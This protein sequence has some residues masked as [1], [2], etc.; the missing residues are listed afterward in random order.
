MA[1]FTKICKQCGLPFETNSPQ[2]LFCDRQHYTACPVCGQLVIKWDRDFTRPPVCCSTE[3]TVKLKEAHLPIKKCEICGEPFKAKSGVATI[4]EKE[5]H[6]PCSVCGKDI[7]ITKRMWHDK[8]DTCSKK[9]AKEKLRR[10]YQQKYG[11]D[12]PMQNSVVQE[13][14][15]A[16]MLAKYGVEHALQNSTIL[17]NTYQTNLER[18]GT[19]FACN[20]KE[21]KENG[22]FGNSKINDKY[23]DMLTNLGLVIEREKMFDSRLFDIYIPEQQ[24]V[25]EIDPTFT[26]NSY[27]NIWDDVVEPGYQKMKT[28]IAEA[29]G[30]RCIHIFDWDATEKVLDLF[31]PKKKLGARLCRIKEVSLEDTNEFLRLYHLQGSVRKQDYRVGLYYEGELVQVMTFGSPRYDKSFD[32]E[33]LRLCTKRELVIQGG[34]NKLFKYAIQQ[35]PFWISIISYCDLAKFSG[36]VYD[37]LGMRKIR[38]T[39]PQAIWSKGCDKVTSTL[40]RQRGYDQLFNTNYGKGTSNEQ[41]MLDNG[42]LPVY[43]CGQAVYEWR[44][45]CE[46]MQNM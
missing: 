6:A 28:D 8:I 27:T 34:A 17:A 30:C 5:H 44:R 13:H 37:K 32:V 3:C 38:T 12:H 7:I 24:T 41:L 11:V 39:A 31:R 16:A 35:N 10:F 9:C 43:D 29:N 45:N 4:C 21:C 14:H 2:K 25:V 36:Q 23:A 46:T 15:K 1:K 26:H 33:L 42:W 18:F 20:R 19:K 22:P 40:L